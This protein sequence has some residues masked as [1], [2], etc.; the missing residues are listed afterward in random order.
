[1]ARTFL[2]AGDVYTVATSNTY[3]YGSRGDDR[4][5]LM[6]G[7]INT[8]LNQNID[9]L[10]MAAGKVTY[11]YQQTG[12]ILNIYSN[13]STQVAKITLQEDGTVLGFADGS[14]TA[15]IA[16]DSVLQRLVMKI[17]TDVVPYTAPGALQA[18]TS[19]LATQAAALSE[20][21]TGY[22]ALPG[23]SDAGVVSLNS[24]DLWSNS[25][26]SYSFNLTMPAEY[27]SL[28]AELTSGWSALNTAEKNAVAAVFSWLGEVVPITF[29]EVSSQTGDLRFNVSNLESGVSGLAYY[30][31]SGVGGDV[32]LSSAN[33]SDANTYETGHQGYSTIKHE[34][35]HA[36]GLKHSFESPTVPAGT[37]SMAYTVMSY[38]MARNMVPTF[39]YA[40]G[41]ASY[42]ATWDA[43]GS[44]Y[45]IYDIDALHA[46][47]GAN[48][49]TRTGNDTYTVSSR[50]HEY[51]TIWDAGGT[52]TINAASATGACTVGL[53]SG[54][55]STIDLWSLETQQADTIASLEAQGGSGFDSWVGGIFNGSYSANF[56]TGEN[57]LAIA[58]GA[59][60]ENLNTGAGNDTVY[61]NYVDNMISTGAGN[62]SIALGSGGYDTVNGGDGTDTVTLSVNKSQ[63]Q[64][65]RQ[66]DNSL[67]LVTT[68]FAVM[69]IGI[70]QVDCADGALTLV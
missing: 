54:T 41:S 8:I 45:F 52:D 10:D 44:G 63:V 51:L 39:T 48:T 69:L 7:V 27:S 15:T 18:G 29:T 64:Q 57:N 19:T 50:N 13:A 17:G 6:D 43:C 11:L 30:P 20:V 26:L 65:E 28:D 60:I 58:T 46:M 37:D 40:N 61:D 53:R 59:V 23:L 14:S 24:G 34:I 16:Y 31:G 1:M 67:L 47:Y 3:L 5:I 62:D 22:G 2:D 9:R 70:E 4:V 36:L 42:V 49:Q 55:R 68:S 35:G 56:Y 38:T 33:R 32:W 25:S 66:A 21:V 12:N